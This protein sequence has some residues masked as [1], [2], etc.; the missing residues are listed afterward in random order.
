MNLKVIFVFVGLIAANCFAD[1]RKIQVSDGLKTGGNVSKN[2]RVQLTFTTTNKVNLCFWNINKEKL[3]LFENQTDVTRNENSSVSSTLLTKPIKESIIVR[4]NCTPET[5]GSTA[6]LSLLAQSCMNRTHVNIISNKSKTDFG[7]YNSSGWFQCPNN[8]TPVYKSGVKRTEPTVCLPN[9]TWEGQE[10]LSCVKVNLM[11]NPVIKLTR[12]TPKHSDFTCHLEGNQS[13]ISDSKLQLQ[14]DS[15]NVP[16]KFLVQQTDDGKSVKC[17]LV[18][19][20]TKVN[21]TVKKINILYQP[22][23]ENSTC[24]VNSPCEIRVFAKPEPLSLILFYLAKKTSRRLE[25]SVANPPEYVV[26]IQESYH[27]NYTLQLF[28]GIVGPINFTIYIAVNTFSKNNKD[29]SWNKHGASFIFWNIMLIS[30][31][32]IVMSFVI[33]IIVSTVKK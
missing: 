3:I 15:G 10:G 31:F 25:W 33:V 24:E 26:D 8:G 5:E 18:L 13:I 22:L 12:N 28:N 17:I 14:L 2:Y 9:A 11:G 32:C 20:T 19:K 6:D 1:S 21:S 4:V 29:P 27:G 30:L 16:E 7:Q 23:I